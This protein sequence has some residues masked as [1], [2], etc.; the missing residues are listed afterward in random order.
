MH[1]ASLAPL[2]LLALSPPAG[3]LSARCELTLD[4]ALLGWSTID[5][6]ELAL[7]NAVDAP[8]TMVTKSSG[9]SVW[10]SYGYPGGSRLAQRRQILESRLFDR[11]TRR[12]A[13][14]R[15]WLG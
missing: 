6:G 1:T 15:S 5:D 10:I 7:A 4:G 2:D 13:E 3:H 14:K 12:V 8:R 11:Q 9:R